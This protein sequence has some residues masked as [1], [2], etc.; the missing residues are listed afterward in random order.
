M[1]VRLTI[2]RLVLASPAD[3]EPEWKVIAKVVAELNHGLAQELG[4]RIDITTWRTDAFPGFH[5]EGPQ[6]Q[7]D[8]NLKIEDSDILLAI[9]WTHF[10]TPVMDAESGTQ[11]E[12]MRAI[13]AWKSQ[14]K[15][16]VM[17]YFKTAGYAPSDKY[18]HEQWAKVRAFRDNFPEEGLWASLKTKPQFETQL[19]SHLTNFIRTH[20]P[21]TRRSSSTRSNATAQSRNDQTDLSLAQPLAD[22]APGPQSPISNIFAGVDPKMDDKM[23][24]SP[25]TAPPVRPVIS[26]Q[27]EILESRL[28]K[29]M[30]S[31]TTWLIG[32]RRCEQKSKRVYLW[33]DGLVEFRYG[34][35]QNFRFEGDDTWRVDANQLVISWCSGFSIE[36]FTFLEPT[37][38]TA[39]GTKSNVRGPLRIT[40]L[41]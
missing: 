5:A 37:Q 41:P 27:Q 2:L 11:H 3:V 40:R 10:G 30:F 39:L 32:C 16:Q 9:F 26:D 33:G 22:E 18:E 13:R 24:R 6:G 12:I 7:I 21:K 4:C 15:P 19:R 23:S 35:D 1:A 28:A 31:D 25:Q 29:T 14:G 8:A 38:T 17:V 34:N 20:K 36:T